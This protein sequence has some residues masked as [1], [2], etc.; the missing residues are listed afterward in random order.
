MLQFFKSVLATIVGL[1]AFIFLLIFLGALLS[2]GEDLPKV[3]ENSVL[4]LNLNS[5]I[6]ELSEEDPFEEL[7]LPLSSGV[8]S[9]SLIDLLQS[10]QYAKSDENI[11]GIYLDARYTAAGFASLQELR[12]ALLDFKKSGKFIVAYGEIYTEG[13]YYL[14]STANQIHLNPI[15]LV[16]LNGLSSEVPFIKGTLEKLE[17]KPLIFKVGDFKSAVEPFFLDKMSDANREQVTSYL[18]SI[19]DLYLKNVAESREIAIEK[20]REISDS[21]LVRNAETALQYQLIT[22]ISYEDEAQEAIKSLLKL[23]KDEKIEYIGFKN[24]SKVAKAKGAKKGKNRIAVIVAEGE[25]VDGQGDNNSIGGDRF[26]EEIRKARL[27]KDIKAVVLRINSPGGSALASD[28]MWR[29]VQL[30]KKEKPVIASMSDLAASGGYYMA[31]G[32]DT[33]VAQPN[34]ITGSIGIFGVLFEAEDLLKNK[35]GVTTDRVNTG[36]FSDLGNPSRKMTEAEK[37]IIQNQVNRGYEIFTTKAAE[38]RNMPL[39][40]LLKVAS[41][42]VWTGAQAKERGLVDVLGNLDDAIAIAAQ[43]AGIADD[44]RVRIY[45]SKPNF[46]DRLLKRS[47]PESVKQKMLQDEMGE[48][49][50]YYQQAKRLQNL[51]GIQARL[52]FE[53]VIR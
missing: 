29:E 50:T 19:Y 41:G 26:A 40:A 27:N 31:M 24:Y 1:F 23:E 17:V 20:L 3:K 6:T 7:D 30:L 22:D 5:P 9:L 28:I 44:Y 10:I 32:C 37:Q 21:M 11:K 47:S 8:G 53:V 25:I 43:K 35:I 51:R 14:A 36:A 39:E 42:R 13:A 48:F 2:P 46:L 45:P 4:K 52:P 34:T 38:G 16:E 33:I 49:Y 18:N 15:G 12:D